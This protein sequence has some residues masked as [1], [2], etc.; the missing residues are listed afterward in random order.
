MNHIQKG[1]IFQYMLSLMKED[2]LIKRKSSETNS[3]Q[4][5]LAE[6]PNLDE[7]FNTTAAIDL[8]AQFENELSPTLN[9]NACC[10]PD[11]HEIFNHDGPARNLENDVLSNEEELQEIPKYWSRACS[12]QQY[13]R[14]YIG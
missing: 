14:R 13:S 6:F 1:F 4:L 11:I 9:I 5:E 8:K 2:F 12:R 3:M 7:W 10:D